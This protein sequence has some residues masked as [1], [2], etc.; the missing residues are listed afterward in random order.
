MIARRGAACEL[1][2]AITG[3]TVHELDI[4]LA[5]HVQPGIEHANR[6]EVLIDQPHAG[7]LRVECD[8]FHGL[9]LDPGRLYAVSRRFGRRRIEVF[10]VLFHRPGARMREGH[11]DR[12]F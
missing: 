1:R 4:R 2:D 6:A 11:L 12:G 3:L 5:T 9:G 7:H 10:V 8:C